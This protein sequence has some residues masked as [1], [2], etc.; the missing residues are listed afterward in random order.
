MK[1]K[2]QLHSIRVLLNLMDSL[3]KKMIKIKNELE[4]KISNAMIAVILIFVAC[5]FVDFVQ[6]HLIVIKL[7]C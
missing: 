2:N 1:I 7:Y 6:I 4:F 5:L 3:E